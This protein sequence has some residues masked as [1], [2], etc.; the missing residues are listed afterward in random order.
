ML[1]LCGL[2]VGFI[3]GVI[4]EHNFTDNKYNKLDIELANIKGKNEG[5]R[6]CSKIW[7]R[8]WQRKI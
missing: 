8:H 4:F 1:I 6:E 3:V 2:F 5:F 7:E